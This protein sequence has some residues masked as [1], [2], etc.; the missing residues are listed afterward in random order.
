LF[1]LPEEV[2]KPVLE[3]G[4]GC[5]Q[6]RL[7]AK[8]LSRSCLSTDSPGLKELTKVWR[9]H[10]RLAAEWDTT[11][12]S[13][14]SA[15]HT[16]SLHDF[17]SLFESLPGLFLV[18]S[19]QLR[20]L[21][22]SDAYLSATM[23]RRHD[24]VGRGVF[25]VFPD[26]PNDPYA[27]GVR[28]VKAS[29]ERVLRDRVS[30]IM[31]LQK[32]SIR[33]PLEEGGAFEERYWS[34][35]NSPVLDKDGKILYIIHRVEDVTDFVRLQQSAEEKGKLT[36]ELRIRADKME[37][38][39][40]Q[41][42]RQLEEVNRN[43]LEAV[44]RLAAGIAHDFNNL[45]GVVLGNATLLQEKLTPENPLYRGLEHIALAAN[46]AADLT[47]QLLAY[48]RQQVLQPRVLCLNDVLA[49]MEPMIRRLIR[50]NIDIRI[51]G[52][53]NTHLVKADPG[54]IEQII[55]NLAINARDAM[56]D[57]GTLIIE[58]SNAM[59]DE[60]Y[61]TEHPDVEVRPGPYAMLSVSDTG[62]G[63]DAET[64]ERIFEPFFTTKAKGQGTGLGLAS[65][66]GIVKQAGGYVW[67]HSQRGVGT[68]FRV[69]L[70]RTEE[71]LSFAVAVRQP[72]ESIAGSETILVVED[73]PMLREL[74]QR[75]LESS[76]YN[77]ISAETPAGGLQLAR[78]YSGTIDMVLTDLIMPGMSGKTMMEQI[79]S[80]RPETKAL[81]M[82]AYTEDIVDRQGQLLRGASFIS[83]PFTKQDLCL[84]IRRIF[85]SGSNPPAVQRQMDSKDSS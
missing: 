83:K 81:F 40:F 10:P 51:A 1:G 69:Y 13:M 63:M 29:F 60:T 30:D 70:P 59:I 56:P 76:G 11:G 74:I 55:M 28:N 24:I 50:E 67:V 2:S 64:Q 68:T 36:E 9:G 61:E 66:Y 75:M 22:A 7:L 20:I 35:M 33:R 45:L 32:Y 14:T 5:G 47:K 44:G 71:S 73:Q 54:Q 58:I 52:E 57:G 31:P 23:T 3:V 8:N 15:A 62:M 27:T 25:E 42:A 39:L 6:L 19:P 78:S 48:S 82:S 43:R 12:A 4:L 21:A 38:E 53:R 85:H 65:V 84:K 79:F 72:P 37:A 18:L 41:R 16:G 26:N 17:R 77:V 34:P 46:R 49:T 80:V